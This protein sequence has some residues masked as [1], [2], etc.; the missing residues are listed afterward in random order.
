MARALAVRP[1]DR[2]ANA[3]EL[4]SALKAA[5][6]SPWLDLSGTI[7]IPLVRRRPWRLP[8]PRGPQRDPKTRETVVADA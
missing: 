6:P 3:G 1:E 7:P 4:W 5:S 2:F 8:W